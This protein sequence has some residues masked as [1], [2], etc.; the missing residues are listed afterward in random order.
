MEL[1]TGTMELELGL[2]GLDMDLETGTW[3]RGVRDWDTWSRDWDMELET[4]TWS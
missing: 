1:E 3:K 2:R 4:G